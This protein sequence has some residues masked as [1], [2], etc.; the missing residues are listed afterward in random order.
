M[1][2]LLNIGV[3]ALLSYRN[4]LDTAGHNIAN[5]NTPGYSRQRVEL[6]TRVPTGSGNGFTGSGVTVSAT[7]R[8]ASELLATRASADQSAY[9]RL[10]SFSDIA[11]RADRLLSNSSTGLA[12][13][14]NEFLT[15]ASALSANPASTAT[16]QTVLAT[17]DSL[18]ARFADLQGQLSGMEH[19][20]NSRLGQSVSEIN[21]YAGA[22]AALNDRIALARGAGGGN[23]PN[24][25]L[26][27]RDQLV[28][29]LSARIGV[30]T[31]AQDDG[32]INV[33]AA[34]GQAL[35][36]GNRAQ[37]LALADDAWHSG[38]QEI[39]LAGSGVNV[40]AQVSGGTLGGLLDARSQ[41]LDPLQNKLGRLAA[42]V[43]N[44]VNT[45]NHQGAALDGSLGGDL[46]VPLSGTVLPATANGGSAQ[47]S[48]SLADAGAL[49]GEDYVLSYNG[50]GWQLASRSTGAPVTLGGSGTP[51]DPY[52]GAG[53]SFTVSGTPAAGDRYLVQPTRSAA[54]GVRLAT[55]DPADI[56]AAS[57]ITTRSATAN[58]G[59]GTISA[60]S[61]LD[62]ANPAL[63][64]AVTIRF[65]SATA[66]SINGAGSYPYTAGAN[67]DLNGWRVQLSGAPA[68]GDEFTVA[69]TPANSGNN[70][71]ALQLAG[72]SS[73]GVLDGGRSSL[74]AANGSLV[75]QTG[76]IA[77]QA[78]LRKDAQEAIR[79]QTRAERDAVSGVNLDEE[80]A[81]LV[82]F[83]Q[84]YQAAARIVAVAD[85]LFQ[86]L[87]QAARGA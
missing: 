28:Q 26:D 22:V 66:Y 6:Q 4:A 10:E 60:G 21:Q 67:L 61:V 2:D 12:T 41:L 52:T 16:R 74:V 68:S 50:S 55:T 62:A 13:P 32:S 49:G 76:G 44:S 75:A 87:L 45:I 46:L 9:S 39:V 58:A 51:A 27:Q 34:G 38:R 82:R 36:L 70:R 72:L 1:S 15:A 25:L 83:Q 77:Q 37:S 3:S 19:E 57:P 54:A 69:A 42:G 29:E 81:D 56:A 86:S 63:Q 73:S 5:A 65:T 59:N 40:T 24:D 43:V 80:A 23:A 17:L 14:L 71:N 47:V 84:A 53:L 33:F 79:A 78:A 64:S 8:N 7:V 31:V 11:A 20:I 35:V 48:V 30:S 85:T 18:G